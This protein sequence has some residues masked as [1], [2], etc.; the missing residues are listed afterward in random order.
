MSIRRMIHES[1]NES[2]LTLVIVQAQCFDK[3]ER[4]DLPGVVAPKTK[5]PLPIANQGLLIVSPRA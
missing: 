3:C 2:L 5:K 4:S 1:K